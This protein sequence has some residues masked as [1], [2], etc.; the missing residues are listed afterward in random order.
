MDLDV[1]GLLDFFLVRKVI[2]LFIYCGMGKMILLFVVL[3]VFVV[4]LLEFF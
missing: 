3:M 4:I 2:R 1:G